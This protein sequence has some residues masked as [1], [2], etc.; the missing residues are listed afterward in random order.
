MSSS[1]RLSI[2]ARFL[3]NPA[4]LNILYVASA[5][6]AVVYAVFICMFVKLLVHCSEQRRGQEFDFLFFLFH[7]ISGEVEVYPVI[8]SMV[9]Q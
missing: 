5:S 6:V 2:Y 1:I 7:I 9:N 3:I 4:P 8:K